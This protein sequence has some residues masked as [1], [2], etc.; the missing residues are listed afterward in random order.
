MKLAATL[1]LLATVGIG[2]LIDDP[3]AAAA[4]SGCDATHPTF[5]GGPLYGSDGRSLNAAIGVDATDAHGTKVDADGNPVTNGDYSWKQWAE[6]NPT[7]PPDGMADRSG[8][9]RWG[10]C[11]TAK[12]TQVHIE[13]YPKDPAQVTTYTRYGAASHYR[14][15]ITVG[16]DNE[17]LLRLP[18]TYEAAGGNT[19][20]VNGYITYKGRAVPL[21]S[22]GRTRAFTT[23][24]GPGCGIEGFSAKANTV[25]LSVS[26]DATYYRF[27]YLAGGRCGAP[28]QRYGIYIHCVDYCGVGDRVIKQY[29]DIWRGARRRFD[30]A[31]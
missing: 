1:M 16:A 11:V 13:V 23:A 5:I 24:S 27:S 10:R 21:S 29:V 2:I 8:V 26:H 18:M 15:P 3:G 30:F 20:T 14:Q 31:F 19:G 25:A 7:F 9:R 4:A 28:S 6:L 12:I 17:I 22:I